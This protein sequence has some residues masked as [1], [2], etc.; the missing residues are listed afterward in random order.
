MVAAEEDAG[1]RNLLARW[2]E[3]LAGFLLVLNQITQALDV[4]CARNVKRRQDVTV[5]ERLC[6][7]AVC[8][9]GGL[10]LFGAKEQNSQHVARI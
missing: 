8:V 6:R 3:K 10:G 4:A 2:H 1:D 9:V 5:R 7:T